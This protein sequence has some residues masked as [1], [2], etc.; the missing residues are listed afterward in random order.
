MKFCTKH[1]LWKKVP[2]IDR[3]VEMSRY[4]HSSG[5]SS[6]TQTYKIVV[7]G[8]GGVGKSAI[9]IQF[10]QVSVLE[11]VSNG[12]AIRDRWSDVQLMN[13]IRIA[14]CHT[15]KGKKLFIYSY[16]LG[17]FC[18]R[19]S[20]IKHSRKKVATAQPNVYKLKPCER[21]TFLESR[22]FACNEHMNQEQ[23]T[24]TVMKKRQSGIAVQWKRNT[25]AVNGLMC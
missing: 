20:Q 21:V 9:T 8:G 13:E 4:N 15:A 25:H 2:L 10:I 18:L 11:N 5:P 14:I 3:L 6:H 23:T 1:L 17:R 19:K 22:G 16:G 24:I 7:V 12:S